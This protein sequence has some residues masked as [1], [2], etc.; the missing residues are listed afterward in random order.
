MDQSTYTRDNFVGR[1]CLNQTYDIVVVGAGVSG[2][3]AGL[4][5]ALNGAETLIVERKKEIGASIKCGEAI[6]SATLMQELLPRAT[7]ISRLFEMLSQ[8]TICNTTKKL[9][10]FSPKS[11]EYE[12]LYEGLVLKRDE[13]EKTMAEKTKKAGATIRTSTVVTGIDNKG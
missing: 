2:L 7:S 8:D 13:L 1:G 6:P 12:F 10:V 4:S 3:S 5:A 11:R 9:C